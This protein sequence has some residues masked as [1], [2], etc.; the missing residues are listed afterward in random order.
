MN[1]ISV[2]KEKY[3]NCSLEEK[4]GKFKNSTI[5]PSRSIHN[6]DKDKTTENLDRDNEELKLWTII[7]FSLPSFGKMSSLIMLK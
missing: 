6:N 3:E 4:Y 2:L 7:L 1:P 5:A